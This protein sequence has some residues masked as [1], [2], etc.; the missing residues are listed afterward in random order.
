MKN[1]SIQ[2]KLEKIQD[3]S[4]FFQNILR[5]VNA[6]AN[7][8]DQV[9]VAVD[10]IFSNIAKY[11]GATDTTL[12]CEIKEGMAILRFSD[13]GIPYD[14]TQNAEPDIDLPAE[15]WKIGGLGIYIVKKM[16]DGIHYQYR[17]GYNV[18][19]LTKKL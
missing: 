12:S 11:S 5:A 13:N 14:P 15:E 16:M 7:V 6:S 3:A 10:E 17:D 4:L 8:I 2:P 1:M 19:T 9:N 18:L